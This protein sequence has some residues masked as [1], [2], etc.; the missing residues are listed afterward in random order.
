MPYSSESMRCRLAKRLGMVKLFFLSLILDHLHLRSS[1]LDIQ[2]LFQ[3]RVCVTRDLQANWLLIEL[4]GG[5]QSA[6]TLGA[7]TSSG[8]SR[9]PS[10]KHFMRGDR[11]KTPGTEDGCAVHAFKAEEVYLAGKHAEASSLLKQRWHCN[12]REVGSPVQLATKTCVVDQ[13]S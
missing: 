3:T 5:S 11:H 2:R 10:F 12:G 13:K 9:P 7:A 4:T 8:P 1:V 6:S